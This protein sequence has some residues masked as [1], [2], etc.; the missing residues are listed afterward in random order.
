M[1]PMSETQLAGLKKSNTPISEDDLK[2]VF[3]ALGL[4]VVSRADNSVHW[5]MAI[6]KQWT[7]NAE[8]IVAPS[9]QLRKVYHTIFYVTR[10]TDKLRLGTV[11]RIEDLLVLQRKGATVMSEMFAS[12]DDLTVFACPSCEGGL[13]T[14][15]DVRG[16]RVAKAGMRCNA[17][18]WKGHNTKFQPYREHR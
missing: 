10:N 7:A 17:C 8:S 14:W 3:T 11:H 9:E 12:V 5:T 6:D 16:G 13:L 1:C 4:R 2:R 18:D 15:D